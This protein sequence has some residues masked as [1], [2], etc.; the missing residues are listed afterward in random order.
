MRGRGRF[1]VSSSPPLLYI[2]PLFFVFF[3]IFLA[4]CSNSS[5]FCPPTKVLCRSSPP[6]RA[7]AS[8]CPSF[9]LLRLLFFMVVFFVLFVFNKNFFLLRSAF[10]SDLQREWCSFLTILGQWGVDLVFTGANLCGGYVF[11]FFCFM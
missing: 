3:K 8:Q 10:V 9:P 5:Q 2:F 11:S 4:T 7:N 1:L 6:E